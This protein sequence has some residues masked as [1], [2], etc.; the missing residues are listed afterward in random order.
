MMPTRSKGR[1]KIWGVNAARA[2]LSVIMPEE[3]GLF[4]GVAEGDAE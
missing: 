4:L 1:F 2:V 3:S